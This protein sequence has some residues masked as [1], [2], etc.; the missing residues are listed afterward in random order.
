MSL[1]V[2]FAA[3]S[4]VLPLTSS[5]ST[6][7]EAM[8][9]AQPKV[10]NMASSMTPWSLIF[11]KSLSASPQARLPTSPTASGFSISPALRGLRKWSMTFCV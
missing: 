4:T 7:L 5:V 11:R 3:S 1:L 6:E 2:I 9:L 8:A 10:W